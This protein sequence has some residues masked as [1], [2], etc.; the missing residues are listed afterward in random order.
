MKNF[1]ATV[2][3]NKKT[4]I[5]RAVISGAIVATVVVVAGLYK[6]NKDADEVFV[7]VPDSVN[8]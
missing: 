4:I 5:K 2:K 6:A 3:A 8:E 7:L 1:V